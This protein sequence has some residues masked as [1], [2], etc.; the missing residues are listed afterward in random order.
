MDRLLKLRCVERIVRAEVKGIRVC[1]CLCLSLNPFL[2]SAHIRIRRLLAGTRE[3]TRVS[4]RRPPWTEMRG[5]SGAR[6]KCTAVDLMVAKRSASCY[7]TRKGLRTSCGERLPPSTMLCLL[8]DQETCA[9]HSSP[10]S[11]HRSQRFGLP[12]TGLHYTRQVNIEGKIFRTKGADLPCAC[13]SSTARRA[14][15]FCRC[16]ISFRSCEGPCSPRRR[17]RTV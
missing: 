4:H 12:G 1:F 8:V 15:G 16:S 9:G 11:L 10:R 2:G 14:W 3:S 7:R 17:K 13:Y 5:T 6:R